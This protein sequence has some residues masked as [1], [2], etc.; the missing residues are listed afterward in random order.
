MAK[1]ARTLAALFGLTDEHLQAP[2]P[3]CPIKLCSRCTN[4]PA[5][6]GDC[7]Y[8]SGIGYTEESAL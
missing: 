3:A 7:R 4:S 2:V 8:C 6:P 1:K 5:R